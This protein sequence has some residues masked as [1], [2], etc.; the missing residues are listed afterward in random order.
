[1]NYKRIYDQLIKTD[2]SKEEYTE[3]HHI[4][5]KCMGGT[6]EP[7]NLKPLSWRAH[8]LAH[9]LLHKIYKEH[10]GLYI[11]YR[12]MYGKSLT[13][14][15]IAH[16][17]WQDPE[18]RASK[19]KNISKAMTG[20]VQP[21]EQIAKRVEKNT[22]QKRNK[23]QCENI[24][25]GIKASGIH[26]RQRKSYIVTKPDGTEEL[27]FGMKRW[28]SQMGF[29]SATFFQLVKGTRDSW[30]GYTCRKVNDLID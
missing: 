11:A 21:P 14:K 7:S 20:K 26:D 9:K 13:A 22:G 24:A 12:L 27:I 18:C 17:Q 30:N 3:L 29:R 2:Y 5:P 1:M 23:K 10:V 8:K 6:D 15:E 25:S 4:V 19:I 28:C 16:A